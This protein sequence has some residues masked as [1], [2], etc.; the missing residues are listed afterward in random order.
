MSASKRGA[1]KK[2]LQQ[3]ITKSLIRAKIEVASKACC[4]LS[5]HNRNGKV[6]EA[7]WRPNGGILDD[8]ARRL[9][10]EN[11]CWSGASFCLNGRAYDDC[12][13][14]TMD[15]IDQAAQAYHQFTAVGSERESRAGVGFSSLCVHLF[16]SRSE[17]TDYLR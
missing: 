15:P 3:G 14:K 9:Y 1:K 6:A 13:L 7:A 11:D 17:L 8:E 4:T 10:C 16:L 2:R 5:E 12:V